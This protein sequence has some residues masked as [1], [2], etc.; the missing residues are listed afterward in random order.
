MAEK[1]L[2]GGGDAG[3]KVLN[4]KDQDSIGN[5]GGQALAGGVADR[6]N[7]NREGEA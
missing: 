2:D 1:G 6:A 4:M 5:T 7:W 3:N